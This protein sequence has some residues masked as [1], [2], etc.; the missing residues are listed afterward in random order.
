MMHEIWARAQA[1]WR[2]ILVYTLLNG[3]TRFVTDYIYYQSGSQGLRMYAALAGLATAIFCLVQ[4]WQLVMEDKDGDQTWPT[5][6][7]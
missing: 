5:L 1:K 7:A 4:T 6:W 2:G 3:M